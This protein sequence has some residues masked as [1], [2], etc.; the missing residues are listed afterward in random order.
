MPDR[1]LTPREEE[2]FA[3]LAEGLSEKQI[4]HGLGISP[5]TAEV[6]IANMRAKV[7][8]RNVAHLVRLVLAPQTAA[9]ELSASTAV[10]ERE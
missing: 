7:G 8:A 9:G 6:H 4:G 1:P 2:V 3:L 10:R 5:R